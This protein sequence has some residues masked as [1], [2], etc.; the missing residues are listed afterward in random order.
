MMLPAA[1]I[2]FAFISAALPLLSIAWVWKGN[3]TSRGDW[4]L[5]VL[6]CASIVVFFSLVGPW[7]FTSVWL[8][9]LL[10]GL[11]IVAAI[12]TFPR[13]EDRS[14]F[15]RR[16][17]RGRVRYRARLVVLALFFALSLLAVK[18]RLYK[19]SALELSFP[20]KDGRYYVVSGGAG[21]LLNPFRSLEPG[22]AYALGIVKLGLLG[23][24]ASSPLPSN[25]AGHRIY[26]EVVYSPCSG[27]VASAADNAPDNPPRSPEA[28][29]AAGNHI[30]I[31][32]GN[33]R[34][35]LAHLLSGSVTVARGQYV[36]ESQLIA[37]VG[38]SGGSFEPQLR[39]S[40][41]SLDKPQMALPL[42]FRGERL[43]MNRSF[44]N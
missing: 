25:L 2:A 43:V 34:V 3:F 41:S 14:I 9:H 17:S 39:I 29:D 1:L 31:E 40:A 23:N 15:G 10:K 30:I 16:D 44:K 36:K 5:R 24:R 7:A 32:C 21:R 4:L 20:L 38:N 27:K 35:L 11:F 6:T 28:K 26:G 18:D 33:A 13:L 12:R 8:K 42:S 19:G 22:Q 37:R